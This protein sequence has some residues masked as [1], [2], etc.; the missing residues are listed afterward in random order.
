M[1]HDAITFPG[2]LLAA[3]PD[4][5]YKRTGGIV[6]FSWYSELIQLLLN[7]KG[8]AESRDDHNILLTETFKWNKLLPISILQKSYSSF[9]KIFI[10]LGVMNHFAE[11]VDFLPW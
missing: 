2:D 1:N 8:S 3:V 5:F 4:L 7:G 6:F 11:Q 10:H 9:C